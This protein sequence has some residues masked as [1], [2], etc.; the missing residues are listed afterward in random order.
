MTAKVP[1]TFSM[2]MLK[3]GIGKLRRAL[4]GLPLSPEVGAY[5]EGEQDNQG[6]VE[7]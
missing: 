6:C 2:V 1:Q 3:R 5:R 4:Q 7:N